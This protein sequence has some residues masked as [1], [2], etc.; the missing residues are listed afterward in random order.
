ADA[1]SAFKT[2]IT[3]ASR[4]VDGHS[5]LDVAVGHAGKPLRQAVKVARVLPHALEWGGDHAGHA[6]LWHRKPPEYDWHIKKQMAIR[7]LATGRR[8]LAQL[9]PARNKFACA[10]FGWASCHLPVASC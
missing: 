2:K 9:K 4:L 6:N 7:K 10:G 8:Q 5:R 3:D 1:R